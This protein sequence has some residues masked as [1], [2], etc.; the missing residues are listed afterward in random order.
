MGAPEGP[1]KRIAPVGP[2]RKLSKL[3]SLGAGSV[4]YFL[5]GATLVVSVLPS[6]ITWTGPASKSILLGRTNVSFNGT[7]CFC[8]LPAMVIAIT[9]WPSSVY[10]F[11]V[12]YALDTS[13]SRALALG[14]AGWAAAALALD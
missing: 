3:I 10:E 4:V 9:N 7:A 2:W 12:L 13:S 5:R 1:P 6:L 8:G 14:S 11:R